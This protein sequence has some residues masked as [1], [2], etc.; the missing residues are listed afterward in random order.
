MQ[1]IFIEKMDD[2]PTVMLDYE[3]ALIDFEGECY[4]KNTFDFFE[5][6]LNW[7][8]KYLSNE[9]KKE[10]TLNFKLT[11]FNFATT[12]KLFEIFDELEESQHDKLI[13]NWFVSEDKK[14]RLKDYEE[15]ANEFESLNIQAIMI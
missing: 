9:V 7:L 10:T 2:S 15:F 6:I 11:Y 3:N 1:N 4:P 13:I 14:G 5:P 12:Q 8:K